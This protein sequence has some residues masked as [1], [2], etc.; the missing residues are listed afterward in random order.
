MLRH[1]QEA[2]GARKEARAAVHSNRAEVQAKELPARRWTLVRA[3]SGTSVNDLRRAP[4]VP[5]LLSSCPHHWPAP[6]SSAS[7]GLLVSNIMTTGKRYI[8]YFC[9]NVFSCS[10]SRVTAGL[11]GSLFSCTGVRRSAGL[12]DAK[13]R[14]SS[15]ERECKYRERSMHAHKQHASANRSRGEIR[16]D[17]QKRQRQ[18]P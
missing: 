10:G 15:E 2:R 17:Q 12:M 14:G 7:G 11:F 8:Q 9:R 18:M 6:C 3:W 5:I 16:A 13:A 4:A 1:E